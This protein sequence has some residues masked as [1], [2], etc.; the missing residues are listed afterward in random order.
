MSLTLLLD[1]DDTLLSNSMDAFLPA[2]LGALGK[3]LGHI[4]PATDMIKQLMLATQ[5]MQ[6]KRLPLYSL[7]QAFDQV[8]YPALGTTK[9]ALKAD[10]EHFYGEVFPT[11]QAVTNARPEAVE[12]VKYAF[13]QGHQVVIAT[14]PLFP[15]TAIHQRLAWAG[16]PLEHYPYQ[17][18]TTY[19]FFHFAK[20]NPSYYA[21]ILAQMGWP[22]RPAVMVGDTY[23]EDIMGSSGLG[24]P[25]YWLSTSDQPL[26]DHAHPLSTKGAFEGIRPWLDEMDRKQPDLTFE[27]PTSL[28]AVLRSTPAALDTLTAGVTPDQWQQ[29]PRSGEWSLTEILCHL[30]DV[31]REVNLPRLKKVLNEENP[32]LAGIDTDPWAKERDYA[33]QDGPTA[34]KEYFLVRGEML[35]L[36]DNLSLLEWQRPAQH[37]IFGPTTLIE[38]IS[39]MTTHDRTHIQQ[40]VASLRAIGASAL[41]AG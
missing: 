3:Q 23:D 36:L 20:P 32:H 4:Y 18:V 11:L 38:L 33:S 39:F 6:Q 40:S 29:A 19:H 21:E 28:L 41:A 7:E 22:N 12:L 24:L 13:A 8:F 26:P 34:M 35:D 9:E 15:A 31:D 37:T 16:L 5:V 27:T 1:L 25:C 2:Y 30:R 17:L 14:N 10:L